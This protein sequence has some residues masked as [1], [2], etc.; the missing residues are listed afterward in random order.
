MPERHGSE[1]LLDD[2]TVRSRVEATL[3]ARVVAARA[4]EGG[5]TG[6]ALGLDLA[7]GRRVVAKTAPTPL[8]I[9]ARMLAHLAERS[10]LPVPEVLAADDDLLV[11]AFVPGDDPVTPVVERDLADRLA[12][13]HGVHADACGFPF[14]TTAGPLPKPNPWTDSWPAFVRNHRLTYYAGLAAADG[15]LP[16]ALFERVRALGE[17]LPDLLD[18]PAAPA[19][20]HG[21]VWTGNLVVDGDAVA[22]VL[23]PACY[24][25][26]PE[27]EVAYALWTDTVGDSFLD[28]YRERA[29]L[30]PGFER[31]RR[32]YEVVFAC[33][34]AWWFEDVG[35]REDLLAGVRRRLDS[36][37]VGS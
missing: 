13:L 12:A 30:A 9:E 27:A 34:Q 19:L 26:H 2:E 29:G 7:D 25:G 18:D 22:A 23:D 17:R 3:D 6:R 16:P 35:R 21:D 36:L 31:R 32:V 37:D 11:L 4:L 24:Y 28:R 15:T 5:V 8:R 1:G 20:L 33:Q 10:S 14:D